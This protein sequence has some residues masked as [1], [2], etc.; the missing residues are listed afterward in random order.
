MSE[1]KVIRRE[2]SRDLALLCA[3]GTFGALMMIGLAPKLAGPGRPGPE[4]ILALGAFLVG[5]LKRFGVLGAGI[6]SQVYLG[7]LLA[8][9]LGLTTA[10]CKMVA[11]AGLIAA[12]ASLFPAC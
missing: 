1:A 4:L 7:E 8:F 12:L 5:Y 2:S 6:G 3:A 10:D 9:G 11:V